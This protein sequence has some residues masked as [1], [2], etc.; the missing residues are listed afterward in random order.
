MLPS[1]TPFGAFPRE[2]SRRYVRKLNDKFADREGQQSKGS[3]VAQRDQRTDL[4]CPARGYQASCQAN[5]NQ[6][7]DHAEE[8]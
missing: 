4:G 1:I 2:K 6:D 5:R 7:E 3:F 8:R